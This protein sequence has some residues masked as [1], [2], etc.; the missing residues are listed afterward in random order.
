MASNA[1]RAS[2]VRGHGRG[3]P[4]EWRYDSPP[5]PGLGRPIVGI[6]LS[7]SRAGRPSIVSGSGTSQTNRSAFA[8]LSGEG[9]TFSGSTRPSSRKQI[10]GCLG[11]QHAGT[12]N[13]CPSHIDHLLPPLPYRS[14]PWR[15]ASLRHIH[16]WLLP[17]LLAHNRTGPTMNWS[18]AKQVQKH[19]GFWSFGLLLPKSRHPPV[20][21]KFANAVPGSRSPTHHDAGIVVSCSGDDHLLPL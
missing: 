9:R 4:S 20:P 10:I 13:I 2:R 12:M 1:G 6:R 15:A 19:R 21:L 17:A 14:G 18:T 3:Y 5:R 7:A 8:P 16:R 11:E